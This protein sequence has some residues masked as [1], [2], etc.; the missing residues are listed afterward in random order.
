MTAIIFIVVLAILI[1]VHELGHFICAKKTGI[2]VDEF[3]LGFPP[4][5]IGKKIGETMYSLNW[6]PFGGFVK[7]HGEN[8]EENLEDDPDKD[9]NFSKK[10][11][12][13]QIL[14]LAGGIIFNFI[15]AWILI[16]ISFWSGV[17]ASSSDYQNYKDRITDSRIAVTIVSP[18]SPAH[19]SGLKPGDSIV[20]IK[21]K[22][23]KNSPKASELTIQDIK[24]T[25]E[26]SNGKE[27]EL[28]YKRKGI[29]NKINV[30]PK[31]GLIEGKYAIGIGMDNVG[32]LSLPIH[33][34]IWE[35]GKFTIHMIKG[36][37]LGLLEFIKNIIF[38]KADF[39]SVTGPVGIA[40]MVGDAAKLGIT[41]LLMFTALISIN[42]GVINLVPFP[43]LD[44]GRI[45]F[46][47][48]EAI[49][50]KPIKP[51]IMNTV[52]AI[53]FILLLVLMFIVTYRDIAR[54]F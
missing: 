46:V 12:W 5:A 15:F 34:A 23:D 32:T 28:T 16:S 51:K 19:D 21:I 1:L 7:I 8:P 49:I 43:A 20:S 27:I 13:V 45:L 2:R 53:G 22:G 33:L 40:G 42:L 14:V 52:N 6:I 31:N 17:S 11:K 29:E 54:L 35:G 30:I 9:R 4:L 38:A 48:I 39:S 26:D 36:V 25:I 18:S 41:Y 24:K 50:R 10:S 47:I 3:G 44:G 37:T